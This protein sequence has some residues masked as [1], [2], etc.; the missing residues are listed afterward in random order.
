MVCFIWP[1]KTYLIFFFFSSGTVLI[2]GGKGKM[3]LMGH[4][5]RK[6][7]SIKICLEHFFS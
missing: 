7:C 3:D 6:F 4:G 5:G 1:L 2:R